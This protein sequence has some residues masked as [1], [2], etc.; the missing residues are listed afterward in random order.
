MNPDLKRLLL[1][2][3]VAL[4]AGLVA[5]RVFLLLGAGLVIIIVWYYRALLGFLNYTR[6]GAEDNLHDLPGV[7]DD[8]LREFDTMRNGYQQREQ[9]L[10]AFIKRFEE[11]TAA[12][13]DAMV[14]VDDAGR[15]EW[16]N[17]RAG[18]YLGIEWPRDRGQRL[19]NLIRYPEL[20]E[21]LA[22]RKDRS[23]QKLLEVI[24][25]SNRERR[26]EIRINRYGNA[27]LLLMARD[28]TEFHL[29]N[30]MR[31]DFIANASHE[32]RTPLTVIAGYLEAFEE[33]GEHCP[34]DWAPKIAQMR[35]QAI[36]MQRLIEDLLKLSRLESTSE[37]EHAGEVR[38]ADM[39]ETIIGEARAL[40][41]GRHEFIR[42]LD[43]G[44]G[45]LGDQ[46]DLYNAFSNIV[47]NA[48]Q[49]TPPGGSI[50]VRW[51]RDGRGAHVAVA[52]TGE[53]IDESHL[54]RLTERFYRVDKSRSR[55]LGG[56]GLGLAIVKHA[57]G[58]HKAR[59]HVASRLGEG[60]LFRCDFP[61]AAVL[62]LAP[63]CG[64]SGEASARP[65][66]NI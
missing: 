57:L 33:D 6:H 34:A 5:G 2:L 64:K 7:V 58:R 63:D 23:E 43:T 8:L 39:L 17:A 18:D 66:N 14:V 9:K 60:S 47:F 49:Y 35:E 19:A 28:I 36:R 20:A 62:E 10:S 48:V 55:S 16:A 15:I 3:I 59:L 32:L 24:S 44:I 65:E 56:T 11:T 1:I 53:G 26:L 51:Y 22:G 42:D 4:A 12:L 27:Y 13:P 25:P 31:K 37:L 46:Q 41:A 61:A 52:D 29:I 21:Y 40:G 30:R 45:L 38:V 50:T 54:P